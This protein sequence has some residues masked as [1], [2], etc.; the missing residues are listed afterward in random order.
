MAV[1]QKMKVEKLFQNKEKEIWQL[2]RICGVASRKLLSTEDIVD[3]VG[4]IWIWI[5]YEVVVLYQ[6]F[7]FF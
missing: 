4:K 5:V 3:T 6:I 7:S 1:L 2:N